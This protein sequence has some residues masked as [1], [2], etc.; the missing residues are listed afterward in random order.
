MI[1]VASYGHTLDSS[2]T[3][4]GHPPS[5]SAINCEDFEKKVKKNEAENNIFHNFHHAHHVSDGFSHH[6]CQDKSSC[7]SPFKIIFR[8]FCYHLEEVKS[9]K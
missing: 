7:D 6:I 8:K 1:S 5:F 9:P 4:C 3:S 2:V